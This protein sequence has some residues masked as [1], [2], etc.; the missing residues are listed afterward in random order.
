MTSLYNLLWTKECKK[1]RKKQPGSRA[2]E[3]HKKEERVTRNSQ[4]RRGPLEE[5]AADLQLRRERKR[6]VESHS[7][8]PGEHKGNKITDCCWTPEVLFLWGEGRE[9]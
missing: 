4:V 7:V 2:G 9:R 5:L 3:Q 8:D 1:E 6:E